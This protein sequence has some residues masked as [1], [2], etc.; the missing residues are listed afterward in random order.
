V[1][2]AE[3]VQCFPGKGRIS[4]LN[5][6]FRGSDGES[7]NWKLE[8]R[9]LNQEKNLRTPRPGRGLRRTE[10]RRLYESESVVEREQSK[11]VRGGFGREWRKSRG[12]RGLAGIL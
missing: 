10:V 7:R 6:R 11:V 5:G 12:S 1:P 2:A 4:R 8:S 9:K 3:G